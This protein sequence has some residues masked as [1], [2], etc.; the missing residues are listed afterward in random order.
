LKRRA[1]LDRGKYPTGIK[2]SDV[3]LASL[4]LKRDS[5]HGDWNYV[6]LPKRKKT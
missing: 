3:E 4:N 1:E 5:S 6:V 2:I